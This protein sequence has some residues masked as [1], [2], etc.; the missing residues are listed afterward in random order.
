M[1]NISGSFCFCAFKVER[2]LAK[3]PSI[4][5]K[6]FPYSIVRIIS[7]QCCSMAQFYYLENSLFLSKTSIGTFQQLRGVLGFVLAYRNSQLTFRSLNSSLGK[8]NANLRNFI[9]KMICCVAFDL[10]YLMTEAIVQN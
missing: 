9:M 3:N 6:I 5:C 4:Q 1:R 2:L 8:P 7:S 10:Q